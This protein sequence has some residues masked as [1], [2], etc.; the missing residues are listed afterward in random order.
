MRESLI[1]TL[2]QHPSFGYMLQP[3]FVA[4]R[5]DI[6]V[7]TITETAL[8]TS[9][10]YRGLTE[11]EQA[12]VQLAGQYSDKNLMAAYSREKSEAD[13]LRKV[14]ETDISNYIRPFIEKRHRKIVELVL[15]T[16]TPVFLR[17]KIKIRDFRVG[18]ALEVMGEPSKMV[19][20]FRNKEI[21]TYTAKVQNGQSAIELNGHF[22]APLA[23]NPAL[24]VIGRQ[25]HHFNDVDEKK[26]R[27]FFSK[28]QIEVPANSVAGYIR[29]FVVQCVKNY[30]TIGE[31]LV[32]FKQEHKP[33]A[34]LSLEKGFD[35]LP[36]LNLRFQYGDNLFAT[37]KPYKK[38]VELH[39]ED[40]NVSIGWYYRN[41]DWEEKQIRMLTD[42]GLCKTPTGQFVTGSML[43]D[44]AVFSGNKGDSPSDSFGVV[45]WLN[46]NN[47]LLKHFEL[48]QSFGKL[49]YYTGEIDLQMDIDDTRDWFDI[50]CTACFGDVSIPFIKFRDHILN[51]IRDYVL[52][53]GRIAVLPGEWFTRFGEMFRYGK[54]SG[55]NIRLEKYHFRV[56]EL[57]ENGY[58][59]GNGEDRTGRAAEIPESL[60]A[61]LRPYQQS[62]FQWLVYLQE[63][64]FGGCLADDM[65]LG[66][67]LQTIA[68]LLHIYTGEAPAMPKAV[69][70]TPRQL[71][72]F[73]E[74]FFLPPSLIVMP[75]SLIHNWL[76]ELEKFAPSLRVY[77]HTGSNRIRGDEFEKSISGCQIVLTSYGIVRQDIH[78]LSNYPFHYL[79]LDESQYIKNPSSQIFSSVRQ[80]SSTYKLALTG[81][82]VENSLSDLWAQMDFLND[83]ILGKQGEFKMRFRETD[84]VNDEVERQMLL[85]IIDPF[86]LRRSKEEVA[87]EL[88]PLTDE[89]V[90]CEMDDAQALLYNE[91]KNR[92]RNM[93]LEQS[94]E[95]NRLFSAAA[96]SSLMRLRL[97]ANHPVISMPGY[98]GVSAKSEQIMAQAEILFSENHKV[99]IFSSFVKHLEIIAGHF[100]ERGWRY[101]WLTGSTTDREA[102]IDQFN[103]DEDV[104]AFFISLKAGG[105]GLNLTAADYVFI[106]DPWWNPAAEMQAVSRAHRIGQDRKVTLYRF[107]T[108]DTVEEKIQRLQRYKKALTDA[109]VRPQ[110]SMKEIQELLE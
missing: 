61:T 37:D 107:I 110:L 23:S 16:N 68:L 30:E 53:D 63:K 64:G 104:R 81:T 7:Y 20:I 44:S 59:T 38:E 5:P 75:T 74:P 71:S 76:N 78:F 77:V 85:K 99:L 40:G 13:F 102:E 50:R 108:K 79:I 101:A 86:I 51:G 17:E 12:I 83:N 25:L 47:S 82:P 60:N 94:G 41:R 87:P 43:T 58:F 11:D 1:I 32:I 24:V 72:L 34:V 98:E 65:G 73:D 2:I 54:T 31:G 49:L 3:V 8:T 62:G 10:T 90:Y 84:V 105:T 14:T 27:P 67:T 21:F 88:P 106:I 26:L 96:L 15:K 80:L 22:F 66:K 46:R 103:S 39:E 48:K 89:I 55:D 6:E 56:K 70:R 52:P 19:F 18:Q 109:L 36:V 57:A 91:E 4:F 100:D 9:P 29:K 69:G 28:K 92:A 45:E 95:E 42:A 97:L 93:L 33:V 35:L